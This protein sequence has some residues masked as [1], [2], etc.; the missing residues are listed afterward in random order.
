VIL[1]SFQGSKSYD[2]SLEVNST[3]FIFGVR[4]YKFPDYS[5]TGGISQADIPFKTVQ[6]KKPVLRGW[7]PLKPDFGYQ[8]GLSNWSTEP[9]S[10]RE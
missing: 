8:F 6:K 9:F 4:F 2:F 3:L 7:D 1:F 5:K 10:A